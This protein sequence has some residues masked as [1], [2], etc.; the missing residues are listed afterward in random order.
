L[1]QA[2]TNSEAGIRFEAAKA[3]GQLKTKTAVGPLTALLT[4]QN[5]RVRQQA[6]ASL[7]SIEKSTG[8]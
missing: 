4:D 5:K 3:L 2:L 6:G 7:Q 1:V 8:F